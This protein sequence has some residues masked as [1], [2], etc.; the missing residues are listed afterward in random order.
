MQKLTRIV[1]A[2]VLL[3]MLTYAGDYFS[4]RFRM[5]YH[6]DPFGTMEIQRLFVIRLKNGK[7]EFMQDDPETQTC[8]HAL[9]AQLGYTPCWFLA[10]HTKQ[11]V[12]YD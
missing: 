1:L 5:A 2:I 9:F 3:A 6:R 12:N 11:Q 4:V 10:R 7:R 8:V